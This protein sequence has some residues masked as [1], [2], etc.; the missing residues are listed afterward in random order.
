MAQQYPDLH[1]YLAAGNYA[2]L[3]SWLEQESRLPGPRANLALIIALADACAARPQVEIMPIQERWLNT[4]IAAAPINSPAEFPVACA[5][6][7]LAARLDAESSPNDRLLAALERA[8]RDRRWRTREGVV[9]GAQRAA[10]R[11]P[12]SVLALVR[13][14]GTSGDPFLERAAIA[15]LAHP[16]LLK[17]AAITRLS[18]DLCDRVIARLQSLAAA[19]RKTEGNQVL[20]KGLSYAISMFVAA[21]PEEGFARMQRWLMEAD[22]PSRR[23]INANL[24]KARL[25]KRFPNQVARMN[26]IIFEARD[27]QR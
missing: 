9:I 7:G 25:S 3:R 26:G 19:L 11:S 23:I 22:E 6:A 27:W 4:P 14:W 13:G 5:A 18:L 8:A 21:L 15:I 24:G 16:P 17:D 12:K 2:G 1:R 10:E 20:E